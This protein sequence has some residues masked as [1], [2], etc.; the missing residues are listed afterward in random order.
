MNEKKQC[1]TLLEGEADVIAV[2]FLI[3]IHNLQYYIRFINPGLTGSWF[4]TW[5]WVVASRRLPLALCA[6]LIVAET[7]FGLGYRFMF[8]G[9]FPSLA[10]AMGATLQFA[11]VC[12]A[13]AVF[14][15]PPAL[16]VLQHKQSRAEGLE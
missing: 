9:R 3:N 2:S 7:I 14:G 13:I 5:C 6:Q 16:P 15:R 12:S 1:P 10:E 4:A 8:E 11:G